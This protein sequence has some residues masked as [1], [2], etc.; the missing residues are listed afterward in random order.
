MH[1]RGTPRRT[2][3][4]HLH[5]AAEAGAI[6]TGREAVRETLREAGWATE[7]VELA[8]LA[9][10]EA[11]AN[12]IEHGSPPGATVE[13]AT[14]VAAGGAVAE[15]VVTDRGRPGVRAPVGVPAAPPPSSDHGRG[16]IIMSALADEL[17]VGRA[18]R[19]TRVRLR[20]AR[21][22]PLATPPRDAADAVIA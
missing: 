21:P 16:L 15:V 4:A 10:D 12:A 17:E 9:A 7:G 8:V 13:I 5:L 6:A 3:G 19:G 2:G 20:F 22:A 1:I 14:T 18:G 11:L